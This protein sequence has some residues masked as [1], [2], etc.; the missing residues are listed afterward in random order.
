MK[1]PLPLKSESG[2][3]GRIGL[4]TSQD[5]YRG[6]VMAKVMFNTS[7]LRREDARICVV[8]ENLFD[9]IPEIV[10]YVDALHELGLADETAYLKI[11]RGRETI[12]HMR[13]VLDL[14]QKGDA[15]TF[16]ASPLHFFRVLWIAFW[17]K[18]TYQDVRAACVVAWGIPRPFEAL[19][20]AVLTV[21]FPVLDILG[22]REWFVLRTIGRRKE[23]VL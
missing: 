16:I 11:P 9:G 2:W 19:T 15:V 22:L 17:W 23:G 1:S 3:K 20:D 21:A 18:F 12:G 6:L 10:A 8:S 4:R 13:A 14:C 7:M 5:W